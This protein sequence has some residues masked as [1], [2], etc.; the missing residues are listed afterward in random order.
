MQHFKGY[1]RWVRS[2]GLILR[3]EAG[4]AQRFICTFEDIT[5]QKLKEQRLVFDS[6]HDALTGVPNRSLFMDRLNQILLSR[7]SFA[8]LYIDIDDFKSVN[9]MLGHQAGDELLRVVSRRLAHACRAGDTIARLGGDEFIALLVNI[10]EENEIKQLVE[11]MLK[12]VQS[13]VVFGGKKISPKISIGITLCDPLS[14]TEAEAIIQDADIALYKAKERGKGQ[15]VMFNE[16]MKEASK[17][18]W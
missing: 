10:E 14:Y 16:E 18:E 8:V 17:I 2:R 12:E 6:L 1:F 3:N 13:P 11:R 5:E 7:N 9:D 15:Y 4:Q